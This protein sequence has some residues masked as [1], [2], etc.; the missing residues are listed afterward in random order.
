MKKDYVAYNAVDFAKDFDFL[1]W[2][3]YPDQNPALNTFWK[4]WLQT[5]PDK[6]DEVEDARQ[7]IFAILE[8]KYIPTDERQLEV[9]DRVMETLESDNSI[10]AEPRV[11]VMRSSWVSKAAVVF[12]VISASF[13]IWKIFYDSP[14]FVS[15]VTNPVNETFVVQKNEE[16]DTKTII[17]PDGTSIVLQPHSSIQYPK[18]FRKDF[19]EVQLTGEAFFEVKKDAS[20]PFLVYANEIVTRVLGTSFSIRNFKDENVLVRVK[21]G[22]V[23]VFKEK[24]RVSKK[25]PQKETIEGVILTPNQQVV[26]EREQNRLTKSLVENPTVLVPIAKKDFEFTDTPIKEVFEAIE[27]AYGVDIVYDEE[28]LSNCFLNASLS[29]VP[30]HEKLKLISKGINTTYEMIDSHI[31]IYGQGCK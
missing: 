2:V 17:L 8:E 14:D 26:Y 6:A 12:L 13:G 18:V 24:E 15:V 10:H 7:L 9:W 22:K 30:L 11:S 31:I 1:R 23:S 5:H 3:K 29:D 27:H 4:D 16:P 19:R 21:T 25:D 20:R 28:V